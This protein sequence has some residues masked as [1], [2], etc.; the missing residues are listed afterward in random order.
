MARP[1][2]ASPDSREWLESDGNRWAK[3]A[4]R[5]VSCQKVGR[6]IRVLWPNLLFPRDNRCATWRFVASVQTPLPYPLLAAGVPKG[7]LGL[8]ICPPL[9]P[10]APQ[11]LLP[12]EF[13]FQHA[14]APASDNRR[15]SS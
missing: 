1:G 7:F 9:W 3:F 10:P 13:Q 2:S 11:T 14:T 15:T 5:H 6:K 8:S 4:R 12:A